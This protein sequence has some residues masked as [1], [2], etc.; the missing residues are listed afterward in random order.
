[1][2]VYTIGF[3]QKSAEKFFDLL[4]QADVKRV[5]DVRLNNSGQLAG[6]SKKDDL[7]FFLKELCGIDYIHVPELAP[8]KEIL[9][10]Y[11]KHKG[12]WEVYE[13]EFMSLME[14]R[15]IDEAI[16]R[17]I[18]DQG[19]LLCSEHKPHHCHRRLVAEYLAQKWGQ[20][21]TRHLI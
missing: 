21:D 2:K 9:D 10:A 8:T 1:M 19:C 14:K 20:F 6:F 16:A 5:V 4:R 18:V 11:K 17:D 3:T 15:R 12:S 7:V 13:E